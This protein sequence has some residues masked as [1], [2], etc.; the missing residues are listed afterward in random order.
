MV[1]DL[2]SVTPNIGGKLGDCGGRVARGEAGRPIIR[3]F[4]RSAF[5]FPFT[6]RLSPRLAATAATR[7]L[8]G[9]L[10][11]VSDSNVAAVPTRKSTGDGARLVSV[12]AS[13]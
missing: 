3:L 7:D 12:G 6:S 4:R 2:S 10:S 9:V 11:P 1:S 5:V 8:W 13:R